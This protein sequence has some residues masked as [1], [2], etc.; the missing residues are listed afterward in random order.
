[1][2]DLYMN[3]YNKYNFLF[4]KYILQ[5]IIKYSLSFNICP[6]GPIWQDWVIVKWIEFFPSQK[7]KKKKK[8][9][10]KQTYN[11]IIFSPKDEFY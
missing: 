2:T 8:N 9:T 1:M 11:Y 7:K 6:Q 10:N 4:E 5:F 3:I